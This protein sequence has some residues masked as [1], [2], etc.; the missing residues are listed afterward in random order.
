[1]NTL[2]DYIFYINCIFNIQHTYTKINDELSPSGAVYVAEM[3]LT[4]F[5]QNTFS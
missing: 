1:M 2:C 5:E 4:V 3:F